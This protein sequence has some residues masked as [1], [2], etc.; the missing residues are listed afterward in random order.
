MCGDDLPAGLGNASDED[1][2]RP[3]P[4]A[5]EPEPSESV[6][7]R[8]RLFDATVQFLQNAA[9]RER[10]RLESRQAEPPCEARAIQISQSRS[11]VRLPQ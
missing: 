9:G 7:A 3:V 1:L 2:L 10:V 6:S 5:V 11:R 8:F 4:V